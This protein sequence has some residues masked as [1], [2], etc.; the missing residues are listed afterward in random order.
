MPNRVVNILIVHFILA[1]GTLPPILVLL[2]T[3]SQAHTIKTTHRR[4]GKDTKSCKIVGWPLVFIK[5]CSSIF[6]ANK[7]FALL[8]LIFVQN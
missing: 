2:E 8:M 6:A 4:G 7:I 3:L 1:T 5:D